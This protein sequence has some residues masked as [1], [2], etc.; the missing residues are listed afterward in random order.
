MKRIRFM[1]LGGLFCC[2]L[3]LAWQTMAQK[4]TKHEATGTTF[5]AGG[6]WGNGAKVPVR[7]FD[8]LL[9]QPLLVKDDKGHLFTA[10]SYS[11]IYVEQQVYAD[12]TGKP[13]L[14]SDYFYNNSYDG[15]LPEN[16][17]KE[18]SPRLKADDTAIFTDI[19]YLEADKDT[20]LLYC[21]TMKVV[22][23]P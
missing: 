23:T 5:L 14:M 9:N 2:C 12:P 19:R 1:M 10:V 7:V 8:S 13:K 22:L 20:P 11:F 3:A 16:W 21:R 15:V 18:L 4:K 17:H 6:E